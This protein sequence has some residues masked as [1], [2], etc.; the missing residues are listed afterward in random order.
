MPPCCFVNISILTIHEKKKN[1]ANVQTH[2]RVTSALLRCEIVWKIRD[3]D[4]R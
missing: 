3:G 1:Y 2:V 4:L